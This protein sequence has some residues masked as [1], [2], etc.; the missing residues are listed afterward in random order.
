MVVADAQSR[1]EN[2][3]RAY[4]VEDDVTLAYTLQHLEKEL[5]VKI[6]KASHLID[7]N[8][9]IYNYNKNVI[10]QISVYLDRLG[11]RP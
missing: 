10:G 8:N 11:G 7:H 6:N 9:D 4:R 5:K 3:K 2:V 1:H